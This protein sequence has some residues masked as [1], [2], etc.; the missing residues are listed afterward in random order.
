MNDK[1][2]TTRGDAGWTNKMAGFRTS[3]RGTDSD[4]GS[5]CVE[6]HDRQRHRAG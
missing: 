6:D 3:I 4:E 1:G 2:K 5:R